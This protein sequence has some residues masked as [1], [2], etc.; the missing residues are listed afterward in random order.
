MNIPVKHILFV[1]ADREAQ[2]RFNSYFDTGSFLV[3]N[4]NSAM[5]AIQHIKESKPA[6]VLIINENAKPM[7][8]AQTLNYLSDELQFKAK[9]FVTSESKGSFETDSAVYEVLKKPFDETEFQKVESALGYTKKISDELYSL[10][11]LKELSDGDPVFINQSIQ[12]F[13]ETVGPRIEELKALSAAKAYQKI[14]EVAHNIKPSFEMILNKRGAELC[15]FLAHH[16]APGDFKSY[17]EDLNEEYLL[18]EKHLRE[19]FLSK[20]NSL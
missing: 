20:E 1:D 5:G 8:A 9:T 19:D 7:G 11:Y 6:D 18:V 17:V 10:D 16:S 3:Y 15:N 2:S 14:A 12:M 13:I 4:F